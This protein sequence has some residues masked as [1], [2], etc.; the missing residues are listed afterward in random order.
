MEHETNM[1]AIKEEINKAITIGDVTF[2]LN[3]CWNRQY[4]AWLTVNSTVVF[5]SGVGEREID[6]KRECENFLE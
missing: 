4:Q 5:S 2:V 3:K 6:W 1:T